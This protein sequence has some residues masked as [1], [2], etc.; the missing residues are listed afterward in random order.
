MSLAALLQCG[1]WKSTD[2][3]P[4]VRRRGAMNIQSLADSGSVARRAASIIADEAWEAIAARGLFVM[5]VSGGHT[6]W[7]M[8]RELAAAGIPWRAVHIFQTDERVAP[9]GHT[10]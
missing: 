7:V 1:D 6:P 2:S 3:P 9:A 8:L 4:G 10:D 5:A